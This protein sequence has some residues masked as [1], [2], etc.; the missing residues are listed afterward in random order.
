MNAL[1]TAQRNA[2]A[3]TLG[4]T[5]MLTD[6]LDAL[7]YGVLL[8][9]RSGDV[10]LANR[11]ARER[12]AASGWR[13]QDGLPA[14]G[15]A[16][17]QRQFTN[18]LAA[19]LAGRRQLISLPA[20][21]GHTLTLAFMPLGREPVVDDEQPAVL[22]VCARSQVCAPLSVT[23][24]AHAHGM[25]LAETEVLQ[26]LAQGAT[27]ADAA[28]SIGVAISTVRTHIGALRAKTGARSIRDLVQR[29]AALPPIAPLLQ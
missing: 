22:V 24:F 8:L 6:V 10:C 29:L 19:A 27:P 26:S 20:A 1:L 28:E 15:C 2:S 7:D 13:L 17:G 18:A 9:A 5:P 3:A 16:A 21:Q 11:V 12:C 14:L 4:L 23:L 25:T